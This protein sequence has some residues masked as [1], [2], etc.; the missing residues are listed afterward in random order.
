MRLARQW[1]ELYGV[2]LK[3]A[4]NDNTATA[5]ATNAVNDNTANVNALGLATQDYA[6][7]AKLPCGHVKCQ[8]YQCQYKQMLTLPML[9]ANAANNE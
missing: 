4:V 2:V 8:H 9:N 3:S 6:R 7:F 1:M 5:N